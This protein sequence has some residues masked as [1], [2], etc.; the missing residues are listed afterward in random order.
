MPVSDKNASIVI[1]LFFLINL[2]EL[3]KSIKT[4]NPAIAPINL[5]IY[6]IH[7]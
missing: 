7:V 6:S 3:M 4:D 1:D 2:S 5:F